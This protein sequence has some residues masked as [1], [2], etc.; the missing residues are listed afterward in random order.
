[1]PDD[2]PFLDVKAKYFSLKSLFV[3]PT[4][5]L[6]SKVDFKYRNLPNSLSNP[7]MPS[8]PSPSPQNPPIMITM[9]T[10]PTA[11]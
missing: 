4:I 8:A 1:M 9:N 10:Y 11:S 6:I 7:S 2:L 5:L 3:I